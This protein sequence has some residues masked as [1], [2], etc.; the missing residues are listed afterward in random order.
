MTLFGGNILSS[1]Q[2]SSGWYDS[3]NPAVNTFG[4]YNAGT[5]GDGEP[6]PVLGSTTDF[7]HSLCANTASVGAIECSYGL[8]IDVYDRCVRGYRSGY[9]F[10]TTVHHTY[11]YTTFY[12]DPDGQC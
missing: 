6:L 5:P 4:I 1:V 11:R 2:V 10:S 12:W 7:S 8:R 3:A 9:A